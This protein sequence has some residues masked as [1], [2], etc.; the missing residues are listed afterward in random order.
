M[1]FILLG[2]IALTV[3]AVREARLSEAG[4]VLWEDAWFRLTLADAYFGF[5]IVYLWV[6]YKERRFGSKIVWLVLFVT[7]GNM[8]V[9]VYILIQLFTVRQ[10]NWVESLLLRADL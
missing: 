3:V 4:A 10:E 9:A 7:L 8:A 6:W 1:I 5:L 2:M